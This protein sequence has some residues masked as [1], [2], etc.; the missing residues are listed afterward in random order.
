VK[1]RNKSLKVADSFLYHV[2][3]DLEG[4]ARFCGIGKRTDARDLIKEARR[5]LKEVRKSITQERGTK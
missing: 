1:R 5:M 2:L 3:D 4:A